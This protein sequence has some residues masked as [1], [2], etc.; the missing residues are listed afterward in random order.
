MCHYNEIKYTHS[1]RMWNLVQHRWWV[2][3][4]R[5]TF[6]CLHYLKAPKPHPI[7]KKPLSQPPM[8]EW[9][10]G[11]NST[12]MRLVWWHHGHTMHGM[13]RCRTHSQEASTP[14]FQCVMDVADSTGLKL[15]AV[16][17]MHGLFVCTVG[18]LMN[19]SPSRFL[20]HVFPFAAKP[21]NFFLI[22]YFCH[23]FISGAFSLL[24]RI[25]ES[26][27]RNLSLRMVYQLVLGF[28]TWDAVLSSCTLPFWGI[29][30]PVGLT[31]ISFHFSFILW[32]YVLFFCFY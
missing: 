11:Q 1:Q 9:L 20:S 16:G 31:G 28:T 2:P 26:Y 18:S 21:F 17:R 22:M 3:I 32:E 23:Y 29:L 6:Y 25:S 7:T 24:F 14:W 12:K 5:T 15:R 27:I 30:W 13:P 10:H 19:L 4:K 8:P